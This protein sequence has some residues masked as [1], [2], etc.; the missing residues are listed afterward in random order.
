MRDAHVAGQWF[1]FASATARSAS[2]LQSAS[3]NTPAGMAEWPKGTGAETLGA[4]VFL[5]CCLSDK[6]SHRWCC[7]NRFNRG[8]QP[9]DLLRWQNTPRTVAELR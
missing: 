1:Q 9:I 8:N 7:A 6:V 3:A 5:R 4:W 2:A